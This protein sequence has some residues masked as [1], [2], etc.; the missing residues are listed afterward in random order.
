VPV[1]PL[2]PA[3]VNFDEANHSASAT[4]RIHTEGLVGVDAFQLCVRQKVERRT[5]GQ[6][7]NVRFFV[8]VSHPK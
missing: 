4:E 1:A 2:H 3:V 7:L 5:V 8:Q 6:F